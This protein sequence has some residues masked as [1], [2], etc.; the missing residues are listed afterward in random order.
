MK[1]Y[2]EELLNILESNIQNKAHYISSLTD[3]YP[4]DKTEILEAFE[5]WNE[6]AAVE[7]IPPTENMDREF[8]KQLSEYELKHENLEKAKVVPLKNESNNIFSLRKLGIAMTFLIGL[9]I[10]NFLDIFNVRPS[11]VAEQ[12]VQMN[13]DLVTFASLEQ[14]PLAGD[15]IRGIINAKNQL[16]PNQKILAALNDVLCNDPN[17][18]VRLSAIETLVL[19][20]DIPEA[21]EILI[22]AIPKQD[23]PI[24]QMELADVMISLEAKNSS[25]KWNQLLKSGTM[26]PDIKEQLENTLKELL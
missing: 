22:K 7:V 1:K 8:Y 6:L 12:S 18:N 15:R 5:T 17:V 9:A 2:E 11:S 21:R 3:L 24:V 23:S 20:W 10:G 13:D 16:N 14:T 19:F 26:E 25:N 4:D